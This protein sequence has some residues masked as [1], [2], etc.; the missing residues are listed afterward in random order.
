MA[1]GFTISEAA[2]F[3]RIIETDRGDL[4]PETARRWLTLGFP[5]KDRRK[6]DVLTKKAQTGRITARERIE[7]DNY[8]HVAD[9]LAIMHSRARHALAAAAND[10]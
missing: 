6:V 5:A 8:L 7:L 2:I 1:T 4:S 10:A 9:L 3:S